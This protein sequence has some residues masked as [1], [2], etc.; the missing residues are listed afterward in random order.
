MENCQQILSAG[1]GRRGGQLA[2]CCG[3]L[4]LVGEGSWLAYL[5]REGWRGPLVRALTAGGPWG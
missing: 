2:Y 3:Q 1:G 4:G 5:G